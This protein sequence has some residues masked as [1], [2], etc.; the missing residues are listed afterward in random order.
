MDTRDTLPPPA[1]LVPPQQ[2]R[3]TVWIDHL[4]AV[5]DELLHQL[6]QSGQKKAA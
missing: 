5:T 3:E 6:E 2:L 1:P 4:I